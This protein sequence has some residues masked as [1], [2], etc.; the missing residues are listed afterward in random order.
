V[1]APRWVAVTRP[2][3]LAVDDTGHVW[4]GADGEAT[5]P[6]QPGTGE[7]WRVTPAGEPTLVLKGPLAA[8]IAA[9]PGGHVFVADR[10][11]AQ[12]LAL[13][14]DGRRIAFARFGE[15]SAPRGL[16]F[17]PVTAETRRAGLAGD[18]FV[19]LINRGA[20]QVNE[21]VRVSGPFDELLRPR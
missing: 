8:S 21:V 7:I 18:L 16:A 10:Q 6:W 12:V 3:V 11:G 4:I 15:G 13:S 1:L 17:A 14:P 20:F 5:A 2:R 19:V 9:G